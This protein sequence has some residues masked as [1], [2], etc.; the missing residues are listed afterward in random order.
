[1]DEVGHAVEQRV[2][3]LAEVRGEGERLGDRFEDVLF[4]LRRSQVRVEEVLVGVA[5]RLHE[6]VDPVGPD[7]LD[8]VRTDCLQEHVAFL[9]FNKNFCCAHGVIR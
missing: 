9:L 5:R 1:V 8:D 4:G 2:E 6:I 7:R 3:V